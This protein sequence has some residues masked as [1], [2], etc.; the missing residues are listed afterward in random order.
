MAHTVFDLP[1]CLDRGYESAHEKVRLS[2]LLVCINLREHFQSLA[3]QLLQAVLGHKKQFTSSSELRG[4]CVIKGTGSSTIWTRDV[5]ELVVPDSVF[6][7]VVWAVNARVNVC[8]L[9]EYGLPLI[10][11]SWLFR[12]IMILASH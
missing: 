1:V 9:Q 11:I 6:A 4:P 10:C 3:Q 8:V 12:A 5:K 7:R 2:H